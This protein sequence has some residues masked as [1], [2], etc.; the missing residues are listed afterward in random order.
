[1]VH[2]FLMIATVLFMVVLRLSGTVPKVRLA[3]AQTREALATMSAADLTEEAKEI[4]VQRAAIGMFGSLASILMRTLVCVG[5][6]VAFVALGGA[7]GLYGME[8]V[9]RA[10]TDPYFIAA[11]AAVVIAGFYLMR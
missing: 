8:D 1:M 7:A 2:V 5:S 4:A 11:S 9:V 3:M 10:S 6:P